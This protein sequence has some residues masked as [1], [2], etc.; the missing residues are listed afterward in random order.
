MHA[1][2]ILS[3]LILGYISIVWQARTFGNIWEVNTAVP[4]ILYSVVAIS[5]TC[6]IVFLVLSQIVDGKEF[7]KLSKKEQGK[8]KFIRR[9]IFW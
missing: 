9:F 1:F 5:G 7:Q 4:N 3:G 6:L 8:F 2:S